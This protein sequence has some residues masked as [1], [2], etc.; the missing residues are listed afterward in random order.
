V[1]SN[2]TSAT[3]PPPSNSTIQR[4]QDDS[5]NLAHT[6]RH[7]ADI[8][9]EGTQPSAALPHYEEALGIYRHHPETGTL[10]LANALRGFA[11]LKASLGET[12]TAIT[13]WREAGTLYNQ[14]WQEPDSPFT[15]ADLEPGIDESQRQ[16]ALLT[17]SKSTHS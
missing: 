5:L 8:L 4:S 11:L 7:V 13:L 9:R 1:A 10:D 15:Q 16:I 3:Q 17:T 6:I 2:A 12:A 14:V